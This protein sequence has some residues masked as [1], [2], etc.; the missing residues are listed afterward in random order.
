VIG[1]RAWGKGQAAF[2]FLDAQGNQGAPV[3]EYVAWQMPNSYEGPHSQRCKGRQKK[4]YRQLIEL[5]ENGMRA[6]GQGTVERLFWS[7]GAAAGKGY[8]LNPNI[9]AFWPH[10]HSNAKT[11]ILWNVDLCCKR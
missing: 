6:N 5:V 1:E 7:N 2:R 9:D 11:Y 8:G 10:G 3:R 4:I